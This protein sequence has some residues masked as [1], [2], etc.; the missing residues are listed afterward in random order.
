MIH[1]DDNEY[2]DIDLNSSACEQV[3]RLEHINKLRAKRQNVRRPTIKQPQDKVELQPLEVTNNA[4]DTVKP[5]S[6]ESNKNLK[7]TSDEPI[8]QPIIR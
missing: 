4:N 3:P 6:N 1:N 5:I 2:V 7:E 8:R